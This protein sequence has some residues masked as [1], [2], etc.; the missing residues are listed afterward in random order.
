MHF[1]LVNVGQD[2]Y[3]LDMYNRIDIDKC[4]FFVD[5]KTCMFY[6]TAD[7]N[8]PCTTVHN[9]NHLEKL[10]FLVALA[11]LR[12]DS[13]R[14]KWFNGKIGMWPFATKGE[15]VRQLHLRPKDTTVWKS[16]NM[17]QTKF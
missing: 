11:R 15:A 5:R 14:Q 8:K 13:G 10:H 4:W 7:E 16:F 1:C 3:F 12:Y 9:K 17:N 6:I 2:G